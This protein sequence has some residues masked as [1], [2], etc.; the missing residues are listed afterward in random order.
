MNSVKKSVVKIFPHRIIVIEIDRL[1]G[2]RRNV[3]IHQ[4]NIGAVAV[5]KVYRVG[6]GVDAVI[7][8]TCTGDVPVEGH[9][10]LYDDTG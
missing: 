8:G 10:L 9:S 7:A 3:S 2:K 5:T 6:S 4:R 1:S